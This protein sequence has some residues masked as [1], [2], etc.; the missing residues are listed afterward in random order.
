MEKLGLIPLEKLSSRAI[1]IK[2]SDVENKTIPPNKRE[3][4][5][6]MGWEFIPTK[7]KKSTSQPKP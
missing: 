1:N 2:K 6:S 7:L 5:E 4:Y 3:K